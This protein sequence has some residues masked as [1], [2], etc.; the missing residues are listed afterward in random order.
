VDYVVSEVER[1]DLTDVVLTCHSWGGH[2]A[3][4]AAHRL[5]GRVAK[6]I[7]FSAV[8]P[9]RGT[10]MT[11]ENEQYGKIIRRAIKARPG[12]EFAA[13]LGVD[14]LVIPGNHMAMLTQPA[15]VA[16][17]LLSVL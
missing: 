14:P 11:D 6:V 5:A 10:S 17:A 4:G 1:R 7:Y 8:V 2:P 13:R 12:T 9:A 3:T 15:I 16:D